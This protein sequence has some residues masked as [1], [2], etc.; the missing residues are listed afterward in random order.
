MQEREEHKRRD[1]FSKEKPL[2]LLNRKRQKNI[3]LQGKM[4]LPR[5]FKV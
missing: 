2:D 1:N 5:T 4:V 3:P